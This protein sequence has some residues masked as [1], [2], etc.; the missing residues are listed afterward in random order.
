MQASSM[1]YLSSYIGWRGYGSLLRVS[2]S[3]S[4]FKLTPTNLFYAMGISLPIQKYYSDDIT[5]NT[6]L[7]NSEYQLYMSIAPEYLLSTLLQILLI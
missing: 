3:Q 4:F 1:L 6:M 7:R 2:L 5:S